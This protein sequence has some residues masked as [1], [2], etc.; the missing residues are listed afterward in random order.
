M[1]IILLGKGK[2]LEIR[3]V[4]GLMA[5]HP[6]LTLSAGKH[7]ML[8]RNPASFFAQHWDARPSPV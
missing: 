7:K 5:A 3:E 1:K 2:N 4:F 6:Y 8:T